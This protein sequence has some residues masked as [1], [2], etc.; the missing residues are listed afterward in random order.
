MFCRLV[1]L[2]WSPRNSLKIP[3]NVKLQ[4]FKTGFSLTKGQNSFTKSN[5]RFYSSDK[6]SSSYSKENIMRTL[7]SLKDDVKSVPTYVFDI[8]D[9]IKD[10]FIEMEKKKYSIMKIKI[11][12]G[13]LILIIILAFYDLI[14]SWASKQVDVITAKSLDDPQFKKTVNELCEETI[15][16]LC[17]SKQVQ[18]DVTN[19]LSISVQSLAN[20]PKIQTKLIELLSKVIE[21]NQ[22]KQAGSS[23]SSL[24]VKD[25]VKSEE[26][27]EMRQEVYK[28]VQ[29]ELNKLSSDQTVKN[30]MGKLLRGAIN[31]FIFGS[32]KN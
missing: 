7:N 13:L 3:T 2:K 15:K 18:E 8:N 19:L 1:F 5:H 24:I 31:S 4:N 30:D 20:D 22:I 32:K 27:E 9:T 6:E 23:A 16:Q 26:F 28:Y 17:N 14:T 29:T 12:I 10:V 25:L 11:F 21:S